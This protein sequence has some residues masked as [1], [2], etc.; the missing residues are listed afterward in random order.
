MAMESPSSPYRLG[1]QPIVNGGKNSCKP[2]LVGWISES[3]FPMGIIKPQ[4]FCDPFSVGLQI[5]ILMANG[6]NYP[7][8]RRLDLES[9]MK[10]KIYIHSSKKRT[11]SPL[12]TQCWKLIHVHLGQKDG[13]SEAFWLVWGRVNQLDR[14]LGR[15]RGT[16]EILLPWASSIQCLVFVGQSKH[17]WMDF[18]LKKW[19]KSTTLFCCWFGDL[20][21]AGQL[22]KD[23]Y[24]YMYII[25]YIKTLKI[26]QYWKVMANYIRNYHQPPNLELSCGK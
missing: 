10:F 14:G 15:I 3:R 17:Q 25:I 13:S 24:I 5:E 4:V 8:I 18:L 20:F 7:W 6:S 11:V 23:I 2:A 1:E 16:G 9:S 19:T 21:S 12:K 22:N 26:N